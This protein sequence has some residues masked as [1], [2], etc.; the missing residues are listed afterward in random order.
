MFSLGDYGIQL[1]IYLPSSPM[2]RDVFRIRRHPVAGI[3]T[4]DE[5]PNLKASV[6]IGCKFHILTSTIRLGSL[7][8]SKGLLFKRD[9]L[10]RSLRSGI[11]CRLANLNCFSYECSLY[12]YGLN[13]WQHSQYIKCLLGNIRH[14]SQSRR[15]FVVDKYLDPDDHC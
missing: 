5:W 13:L 9:L 10:S 3:E 12:F 15:L 1:T 11:R 2:C 4:L 14:R 8:S 6:R 7:G